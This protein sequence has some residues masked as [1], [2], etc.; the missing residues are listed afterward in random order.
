MNVGVLSAETPFGPEDDTYHE[1]SDDPRETETTWWSL[2]VPERGIGAWLRA[3]YKP[4]LGVVSWHVFAWD[5][6]GATPDKLAYYKAVDD[7]PMD[8]TTA[9]LRD[10]TFPAGGVRVRMFKPLSDYAISY[11][12]E[13]VGFAV[14]VEHRSVHPPH[15]FTPG[16]APMMNNPHLDQLGH[17]T[18]TMTLRGETFPIDCWS[19]RDRTWGPRGGTH[20]QSRKAAHVAGHH[21]VRHP[22]GPRWRQIERQRGRGRIE[23]IFGHADATTGFLG[24]VRPQD[25]DARG[26]SPINV[27]W[28]LKD[29]EFARLDKSRSRMRNHRDPVTGW[30]SHIDAELVDVTGRSM[31]VEGSAIAHMCEHGAGAHALMRWEFEGRIGWGEDQDV[32]RAN[33]FAEMLEALRQV[34]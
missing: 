8:R 24:F 31:S 27:G 12:D 5:P 17:V 22:G 28:L 19:V 7:V 11:T 1:L 13:E 29:G 9:D 18:G 6:G 33:H 4:N 2:N 16:E 10:I 34:R 20:G 14:A 32:W 23:Y 26:R 21:P 30:T 3:A 25:G 15:R